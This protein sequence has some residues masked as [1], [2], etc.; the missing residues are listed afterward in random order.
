MDNVKKIVFDFDTKEENPKKHIMTVTV[1]DSDDTEYVRSW[2]L[3]ERPAISVLK[4]EIAQGGFTKWP[5]ET[6]EETAA[7]LFPPAS[8]EPGQLH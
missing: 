8:G 4:N 7:R 3:L 1:T 2:A 6:P 5:D